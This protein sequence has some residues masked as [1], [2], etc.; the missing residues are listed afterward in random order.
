MIAPE[1]EIYKYFP[2]L[3]PVCVFEAPF[4]FNNIR[5][6]RHTY[7]SRE[8]KTFLFYSFLNALF[9]FIKMQGYQLYGAPCNRVFLILSRYARKPRVATMQKKFN[10]N[11]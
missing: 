11:K 3:F 10:S 7:L 1:N 2:F 6:N 5:N 9:F 8:R 4:N